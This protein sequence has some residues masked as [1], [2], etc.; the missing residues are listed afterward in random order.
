MQTQ[1]QPDAYSG[2]F[3]AAGILGT[4]FALTRRT[5]IELETTLPLELMKRDGQAALVF[6]PAGWL[7]VGVK[8]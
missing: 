3:V 1:L 5:S 2:M 7:G 4:S 8:L 6:A